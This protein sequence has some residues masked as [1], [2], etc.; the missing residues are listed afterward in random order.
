MKSLLVLF[1]IVFA[2]GEISPE[3]VRRVIGPPSG[4]ATGRFDW[5]ENPDRYILWQYDGF[6][7][8]WEAG[9]IPRVGVGSSFRIAGDL[10]GL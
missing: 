6:W 10:K 4:S 1:L 5:R 8:E 7:I 2:S 9:P 3:I